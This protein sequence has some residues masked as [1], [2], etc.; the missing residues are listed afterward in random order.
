VRVRFADLTGVVLTFDDGPHP[1]GTP[2][3]LAELERL[4]ARA[5][6]FVIGE[7]VEREP[8]LVREILAAGHEL[9]IHGYRHQS[10]RQWTRQA[11]FDDV[12][13]ALDAVIDATDVSPRF[14][15]PPHGT[16]T[17]AALRCV[18]RLGL[19]ALLWSR[20]GKDWRRSATPQSIARDATAGIAR[21]EIVLLHD[22]DA[23]GATD[24][25]R[26]TAAAAPLVIE[27]IRAAGHAVVLPPR[28]LPP[29][30]A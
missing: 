24:S 21:G 11:A 5:I 16:M 3:V 17:F 27:A 10:R 23:H 28:V 9:G 19:E 26:R 13:R 8:T 12:L 15:R 4:S 30:V 1:H 20:W 25:W 29:H 18:R 6:F 7:A 14:Y 22:S 2:A